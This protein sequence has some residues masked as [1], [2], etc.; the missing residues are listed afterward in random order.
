V[1]AGLRSFIFWNSTSGYE[2]RPALGEP[3]GAMGMG[4]FLLAGNMLLG[5]ISGLWL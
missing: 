5:M 2:K 4:C 3:V 1:L